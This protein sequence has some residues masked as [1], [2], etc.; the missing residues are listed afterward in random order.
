MA[1][2][3][4]GGH[5]RRLHLVRVDQK[6]EPGLGVLEEIARRRGAIARLAHGTRELD[7]H[8]ASRAG[9]VLVLHHP[10]GAL[11]A[12]GFHNALAKPTA[13]LVHANL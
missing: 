9:G 5:E 3:A 10:R 6:T 4:Q 8:H 13:V 1:P 12:A 11:G 2:V 7:L